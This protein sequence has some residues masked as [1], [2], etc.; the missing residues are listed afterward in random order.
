MSL[1]GM[2]IQNRFPLIREM[3]LKNCLKD[4]YYMNFI[5][6]RAAEVI[7]HNP[8]CV[9]CAYR[10][11][12][13]GGCRASGLEFSGQADP[14]H[15][16]EAACKLFR[17]GWAAKLVQMLKTRYPDKD[18]PI[19]HDQEF[20]SVLGTSLGQRVLEYE[21]KLIKQEASTRIHTHNKQKQEVSK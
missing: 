12:C 17:S 8:E 21:R 19:L 13:Q 2:D 5:S 15:R 11:W 6:S 20:I 3:G 16:D 9:E 10:K 14:F 18:S 4:S 7:E 1:S